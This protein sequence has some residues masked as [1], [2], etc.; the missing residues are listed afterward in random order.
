MVVPTHRR[1]ALLDRCLAALVAQDFDPCAYEVIVVDDAGCPETRRVVERCAGGVTTRP[2]RPCVRYLPVTGTHGPAAARN[3]GWRAAR[4]EFVAFTD[5]DCIPAPGWLAASVSALEGENGH[6]RE[7][8][9]G[10]I[11][12]PIPGEPTDYER[13]A[14]RLEGAEFA[15]ANCV[16]RQDVLASTGG[17]DERFTMA[18]R[19]DSDLHFTLLERGC[20]LAHAPEAVVLHPV[21]PAPWGVSL[22]QQRKNR[23]NALL[24]KK[25]PALYRERVQ[26]LPPWRYYA[27]VAA[28]LGALGG[29]WSGHRGLALGASIAWGVMTGAFCLSRL[30][31]TSRGSRHVLEMMVTSALIPP[32]AVYWRLRGALEFRVWFL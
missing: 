24:Y 4:G 19:E 11:V 6:R 32:A 21:R 14:A 29:A 25:H 31:G 17:F 3:L 1:P 7:G 18:W 15:T 2:G 30:R 10:P 8:A 27:I 22:A 28:G 16:Y 26:P 20:R 9:W 12:V 13:N 5:D 23:F